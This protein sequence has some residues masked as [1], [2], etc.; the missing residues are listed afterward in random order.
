[1]RTSF[2]KPLAVVAAVMVAP[3]AARADYLTGFTGFSVV[4]NATSSTIPD[5]VVNLAVY[6]NQSGVQ[7]KNFLNDIGTSK[8]TVQ[9][10]DGTGTSTIDTSARYVYLFE[11]VN[12]SNSSTNQPITG[13]NIQVDPNYVTGFGV[14]KNQVFAESGTLLGPGGT[15]TRLDGAT[16]DVGTPANGTT[17]P[18]GGSGNVNLVS[19]AAAVNDLSNVQAGIISTSLFQQ[20]T[21]PLLG[22][23]LNVGTPSATD[24]TTGYSTILFFTS[25]VAPVFRLGATASTD[26]T[27]GTVFA[28]GQVPSPNPTPEPGTM[29][30]LAFGLPLAGV[31]YRRLRARAAKVTAAV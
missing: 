8:T 19:A 16:A 1:M 14:L 20:P 23:K 4:P 17:T 22:F 15:N 29:A 12:T 3:A 5:G 27:G 26:S 18:L 24:L 10:L 13:L 21:P 31:G 28:I 25:N 30:L 11:V 7:G 2:L 6:D 9:G